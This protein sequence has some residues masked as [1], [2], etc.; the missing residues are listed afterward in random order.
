MLKPSLLLLLAAFFSIPYISLA[1]EHHSRS[2]EFKTTKIAPGFY[3]LQGSGG[4]ILLS[5]GDDGLLIIDSDYSTMT[6]AL[7]KA[8]SQFK[9]QLKYVLNTHWHSD[10]TEGNLEL[11]K[12]ATIIAHDNVYTRL[13]SRQEI[14]LFNKVVEPYPA[15][16]LPVITFDHSLTLHFNGETIKA[17]HYPHGHTDGDSVIFFEESNIVHMGDHL[18]NGFYPFVDLDSKGSV[19]GMIENI[20]KVLPMI[21]DKTIVVP[22]HGPLA[23]KQDLIAFRDMLEGTSKEVETMQGKSMSL[24]AMQEKG[25]SDKWDSWEDGFLPEKVWIKILYNSLKIQ[26]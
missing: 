26:Y 6:P 20:D 23:N 11:G 14:K 21:G 4:N 9:G 7:K 2:P 16:G 1:E 25:L 19:K 12:Q 24:E 18:F 5:E 10:H 17:I 13:T 8:L 15:E 22:G 3:F